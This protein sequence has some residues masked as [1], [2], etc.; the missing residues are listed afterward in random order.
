MSLVSL[1]FSFLGWT[2]CHCTDVPPRYVPNTDNA[3]IC[4]LL[5]NMYGVCTVSLLVPAADLGTEG[6]R[7]WV[8][9]CGRP[10][11]H[12]RCE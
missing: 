6:G 12:R 9:L 2:V 3:W 5:Y 1:V 7:V 11:S 8:C 10:D 4:D